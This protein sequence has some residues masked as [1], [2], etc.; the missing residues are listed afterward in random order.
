[1]ILRKSG[2]IIIL[3]RI[4]NIFYLLFPVFYDGLVTFSPYAKDF[5]LIE[6]KNPSLFT[7]IGE[8]VRYGEISKKIATKNTKL[9]R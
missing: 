4:A 2:I 9:Y 5:Y 1:M 3:K 8:I 6:E 7:E